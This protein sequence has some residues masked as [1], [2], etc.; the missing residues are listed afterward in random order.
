MLMIVRQAGDDPLRPPMGFG[1]RRGRVESPNNNRRAARSSKTMTIAPGTRFGSYEIAALIGV[2][3]MGEV[4][5]ARDTSLKRDVALKVLHGEFLTD[6]NRLARLQREAEILASLNHANVAHIYG[7]ER[8]EGRTVLVMELIDGITLA[9]R[10]AQGPL[11]PNE[12]L[13]IVLQIAA[14]LEAAHEHGIVHRDLK[15]TNVKLNRDDNVKVLDFGIAKARDPRASDA[16]AKALTTPAMTEAGFLLGTAAYMAPEQARGKVVDTRADIWAFGCV[17][18]ELLAGRPAFLGDDVSTTL[19]RVLEREPDMSALP[20][21]V[22]PNVRTTI[23]LCLKKDVRKRIADIRDVR[24]ALEGTFESRAASVPGPRAEML[25]RRALP[26]AAVLGTVTVAAAYLWRAQSTVAPPLALPVTRFVVTPPATAPLTSLGGYDVI[27]SPDGQRLVYIGQEPTGGVALYIRE[28]DGLEVR[29]L[30]GTD[31]PTA[32]ATQNPFFSPDG[33]WIGFRAPDRG[34]VRVLLD[35]GLVRKIADD[36]QPLFLGAAWASDDTL[37]Y[38]SGLQLHRVS[39]LGGGVPQPLTVALESAPASLTAPVLLPGERAVLFGDNI[40]G[41]ERVGVLDLTT[42][43]RKILIEGGQ[44]PVYAA[45]GHL[46]FARGTTL[47]AAPFNLAELAVTGEPVAVLQGV[48][49]ASPSVA[50]DYAL[51]PTG[52]LVYVPA[53]VEGTGGAN[54]VWVDRDGVASEAFSDVVPNPRD[55]RLSPDGR[56]LLLVTGPVGDAE[57]WLYDLGGR[58]RTP[59]SLRVNSVSA[60]WSPDGTEVAYGRFSGDAAGTIL[61]KRSDDSAPEARE[62]HRGVLRGSPKH[63]SAVD[64]LVFVDAFQA[65]ILAIPVAGAGQTRDVVVT[66]DAEYDPALSPN[67]RWLAYASNRTGQT[68]VWVKGYPDGPPVRVSSNGGYEPRWSLDGREL[69]Y[70]QGRAMMAIGVETENEFSFGPPVELFTGPY[71]LDPAS[72]SASYDIASDGRFLMIQPQPNAGD[73]AAN[74]SSIVVVQ[75]W[76]EELKR[77]VP[78]QR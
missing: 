75:N 18:Y 64:E 35:G 78:A 44:N 11:S 2:G 29:R 6:A 4:Y 53:T 72:F 27:I 34:L 58:P 31:L 62:L 52:T 36:P 5:R 23:E 71:Y 50:A 47:M 59:L 49:H 14:A 56:R 13:G 38:S 8:C 24:L 28:I 45:T 12:A 54:L 25:W 30:P 17:L 70:L 73:D 77:R 65:D 42:G 32:E 67:G 22:A 16:S 39:A 46:V 19:A 9:E 33:D 68:E 7:L 43:K 41:L 55:P 61:T 26:M 40:P 21:N 10:I 48:R 74:Q 3:G 1:R 69:F 20:K 15:P 57:L 60:V 63:W 66:E 51:S 37:I 76:F